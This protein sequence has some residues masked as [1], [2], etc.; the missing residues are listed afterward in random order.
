MVT[1]KHGQALLERARF[2]MAELV[3]LDKIAPA[4]VDAIT[5]ALI[6]H[7]RSWRPQLLLAAGGPDAPR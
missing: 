5:G 7:V 3:E 2:L 1:S 6:A 4:D